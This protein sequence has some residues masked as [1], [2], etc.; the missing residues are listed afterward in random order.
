MNM[1]CLM[2]LIPAIIVGT[3]GAYYPNTIPYILML[4][5]AAGAYPV[6]KDKSWEERIASTIIVILMLLAIFF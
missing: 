4:S 2:L 6:L 3:I 1:G 5:F